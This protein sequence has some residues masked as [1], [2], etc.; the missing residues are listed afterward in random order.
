[1]INEEDFP[2]QFTLETVATAICQHYK[3]GPKETLTIVCN[4]DEFQTKLSDQD[5]K[6]QRAD[7][8]AKIS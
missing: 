3:L 2:K 7:R 8:F 5:K 6:D 4:L 1:M